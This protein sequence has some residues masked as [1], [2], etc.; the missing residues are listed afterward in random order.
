MICPDP[1]EKNFGIKMCEEIR[2]ELIRCS[3]PEINWLDHYSLSDVKEKYGTL[4]WYDNGEPV[5]SRIS[6]IIS[7]YEDRSGMICINCG[8]YAKYKFGY[9]YY[10]EHCFEK[11]GGIKTDKNEFS[12]KLTKLDI[13]YRTIWYQDGTTKKIESEYKEEMERIW[14]YN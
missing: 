6:D 3:T 8:N 12:H 5:N 10:C 14:G 9:Y 2:K 4:R 1:G 13:P 7:K 11:E